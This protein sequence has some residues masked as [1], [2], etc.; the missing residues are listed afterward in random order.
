[1][2]L[3]YLNVKKIGVVYLEIILFGHQSSIWI[4]SRWNNEIYNFWSKISVIDLPLNMRYNEKLHDFRAKNG[5]VV[6]NGFTPNVEYI[7]SYVCLI[8]Y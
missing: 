8:T 2:I 1:M 5:D 4:Y 3:R 7:M 6:Q